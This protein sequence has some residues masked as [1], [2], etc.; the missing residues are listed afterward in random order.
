MAT[1]LAY[2][3]GSVEPVTLAEAKT[4][5]RVDDDVSAGVSSLDGAVTVAIA[6]ARAQAELLTGRCYRRQLRRQELADWPS[7]SDSIDVYAATA[8]A[9]AY[10]DGSAFVTLSGSAYVFAPGGIGNNGTALAPVTDWPT[11]AD[12]PIG[13]RVRI[14]L[15]AGPASAADVPAQVKQYIT[16]AVSAWLDQPGGLVANNLQPHPFLERLLDG[17]RLWV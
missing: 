13:P 2:F 4:A 16:A 1:F 11:L 14:D 8:C 15:T 12:R 10:W 9:V 3:D 7:L 5:A 17:E 6:A